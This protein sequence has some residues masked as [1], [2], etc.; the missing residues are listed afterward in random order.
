MQCYVLFLARIKYFVL[1]WL[2]TLFTPSS[3]WS[4]FSSPCMK[5]RRADQKA[6]RSAAQVNQSHSGR[7]HCEKQRRDQ[8]E[9]ER[10][11]RRSRTVMYRGKKRLAICM[12]GVCVCFFSCTIDLSIKDRFI[13]CLLLDPSSILLDS[14]PF[15]L[16]NTAPPVQ[17]H[18]GAHGASE[19]LLGA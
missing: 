5:V 11:R 6:H 4:L 13:R 16:F 15:F 12:D 9:L 7:A 14:I 1:Y 17:V 18:S 3:S 8:T 19:N 2:S 10:I